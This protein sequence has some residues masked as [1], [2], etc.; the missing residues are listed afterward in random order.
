MLV[1]RAQNTAHHS[2][3]HQCACVLVHALVALTYIS[4]RTTMFERSQPMG[5]SKSPAWASAM[6]ILFVASEVN[7][8]IELITVG[9]VPTGSIQ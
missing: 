5:A 1:V 8:C 9:L 3:Y 4:T 2:V 6:I 7:L